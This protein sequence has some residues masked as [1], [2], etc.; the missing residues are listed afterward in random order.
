MMF[1]PPAAESRSAVDGLCISCENL[2]DLV[3]IR[4]R[5]WKET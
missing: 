4:S 5:G 2:A 3:K 1:Y